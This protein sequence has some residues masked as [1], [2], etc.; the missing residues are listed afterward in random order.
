MKVQLR[1]QRRGVTKAITD[2]VVPKILQKTR[3]LP[4]HRE[5][6]QHGDAGFWEELLRVTRVSDGL[7][8]LRVEEANMP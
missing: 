4:V 2:L 6:L 7:L 8:L 3:F 5:H 1:G